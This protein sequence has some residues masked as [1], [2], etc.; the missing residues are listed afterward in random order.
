VLSV[1]EQS[2]DAKERKSVDWPR[3]FDLI[4]LPAALLGE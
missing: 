2:K 3:L 4:K 1:S